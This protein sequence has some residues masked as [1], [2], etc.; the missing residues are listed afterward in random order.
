MQGRSIIVVALL[1]SLCGCSFIGARTGKFNSMGVTYS[2]LDYSLDNAAECNALFL[3]GFPPL[4]LVTLP[5]SAVDISSS[6]V[7]DTLIYPVDLMVREEESNNFRYKKGF[8]H[9]KWD[10]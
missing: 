2:G 8:C 3:L 5:I 10:I 6:A 7:L 1:I 4:L 9:V